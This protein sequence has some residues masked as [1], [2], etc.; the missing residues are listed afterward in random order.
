MAR[1]ITIPSTMPAVNV[2]AS[3]MASIMGRVIGR[4]SKGLGA[5]ASFPAP[6]LG[7]ED[8]DVNSEASTVLQSQLMDFTAAAR[9]AYAMAV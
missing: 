9:M 6:S 5:T 1:M 3:R 7:S 4:R 2:L 8:T